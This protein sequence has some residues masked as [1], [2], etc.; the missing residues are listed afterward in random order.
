MLEQEVGGPVEPDRGLARARPALHHEAGV[1]R[2]PDDVV[3]LGLDRGDDLAHRP[4]AGG[5]HL[6]EHR[7]GDPARHRRALGIVEVLVVVPDEVALPEAVPPAQGQVER[8]GHGGSVERR[9]HARP[10]VDHDRQVVAVVDVALADAEHLAPGGV[11]A[12]EEIGGV[13]RLEVGEGPPQD[14]LHVLAGD[15]VGGELA[16]EHLPVAVDH[17]HAAGAS[18]LE[19]IA[20]VGEVGEHVG[21][22]HGVVQLAACGGRWP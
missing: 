15:F 2:G 10:P 14:G 1:E 3:L 16:R 8:V 13:G 20:L 11:D 5:T 9:R 6:G 17:R 18:E 4:G 19:P 21:A 22:A 12:P 7:V